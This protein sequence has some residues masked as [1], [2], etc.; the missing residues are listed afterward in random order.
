MKKGLFIIAALFAAGTVTAQQVPNGGFENWTNFGGYEDPDSWAT[1]NIISLLG[2]P[3]TVSKSTDAHSGTY[4]LE[5][6]TVVSDLGMPGNTDT[7]QG[8]AMLGNSD[9]MAGEATPG[10]AF[11]GTPDSLVG[12]Y[13]LTSPNNIPCFVNCVLSYW[14][15][16][17]REE[18]AAAIFIGTG[19]NAYQRFSVPVNYFSNATP[20]TI[21][22]FV[23]NTTDGELE[24]DNVLLLDDLEFIYNSA[25]GI[26]EQQSFFQVSPNPAKDQLLVKSS[27]LPSSIELFDLNGRSVLKVDQPTINTVIAIDDLAPGTFIC[28]VV[29][30]DGTVYQ[31]RIIKQ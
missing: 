22:M 27:N 29:S 21:A 2:G 31:E 9:P 1:V 3:I 14:N 4:A 18:I 23:L 13:K 17:T 26:A 25:A 16:G 30:A 10:A 15:N 11:S 20:D 7:I 6:K 28:N 8:I 19:N 12:W 5:S 24:V